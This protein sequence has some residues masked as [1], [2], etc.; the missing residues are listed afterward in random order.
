MR[1]K[2]R[3]QCPDGPL[4]GDRCLACESYD[5]VI[6]ASKGKKIL[7]KDEFEKLLCLAGRI[8]G[9]AL[10]HDAYC[11][12]VISPSTVTDTIG[13]VWS[14]AEFPEKSLRRVDWLGMFAVAGFT[15]NGKL[16]KKPDHPV[17]L[18][19]GTI[20]S[21][22]RRMSW[23]S[24]LAVAEKFAKVIRAIRDPGKVYE[25]VAP[26]SALLCINND[27]R[28]EAEHVIDPAGLVIRAV[29]KGQQGQ[30]G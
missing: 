19:R 14:G 4:P 30:E 28:D 18:Y 15:I 8:H 17:T 12:R 16:A 21:R 9:P 20:P 2:M 26:P 10:L 7:T 3:E 27:D 25:T 11:F 13:Y 6:T 23:T 24:D 1:A 29:P 22:A 5:A